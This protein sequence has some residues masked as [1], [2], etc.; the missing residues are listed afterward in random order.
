MF[1][2]DEE[3]RFEVP[4]GLRTQANVAFSVSKELWAPLFHL[5]SAIP[6]GCAAVSMTRAKGLSNA[7]QTSF[8]RE[9]ASLLHP[10]LLSALVYMLSVCLVCVGV[11]L[12]VCV[13]MLSVSAFV[14]L[15]GTIGVVSAGA[16]RNFCA[17]VCVLSVCG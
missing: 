5:D 14:S 1:P 4:T 17:C 7:L 8:L 6:Q 10:T 13:C 15:S 16:M 2:L 12:C 9:R 3:A 11:C